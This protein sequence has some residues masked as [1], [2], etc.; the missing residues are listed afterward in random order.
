ML[1]QYFRTARLGREVAVKFLDACEIGEEAEIEQILELFEGATDDQIEWL[2]RQR[3]HFLQM[4]GIELALEYKNNTVIDTVIE[5]IL[6]RDPCIL[7]NILCSSDCPT[8]T[9]DRQQV[10]RTSALIHKE[11]DIIEKAEDSETADKEID[12]ADDDFENGIDCCDHLGNLK[13]IGE[14]SFFY[15]L[16]L[17]SIFITYYPFILYSFL[18]IFFLLA[19]EC[20]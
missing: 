19:K 16:F 3:D 4:T 17:I 8:G 10:E 20:M 1:L 12:D 15:F 18:S 5:Y 7:T 14:E 11:I 9:A 6:K 2:L 13:G